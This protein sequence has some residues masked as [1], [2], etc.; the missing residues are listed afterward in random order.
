VC[1]CISDIVFYCEVI[2][3]R[4]PLLKPGQKF[5]Y[6]QKRYTKIGPITA[7]EAGSGKPCMIRRSAEVTPLDDA[8]ES[9][10]VTPEQFSK[11]QVV[12]LL[13]AYQSELKRKLNE[14]IGAEETLRSVDILHIVD[15]C[16]VA[17]F[18]TQVNQSGAL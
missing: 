10:P 17:A 14:T 13:K 4:F 18:L 1:G 5:I 16:D 15:G 7:S 9:K 6:Q 3:M 2:F 11:D 8:S 12:V